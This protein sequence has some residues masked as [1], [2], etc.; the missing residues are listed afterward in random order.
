MKEA[1]Y[2]FFFFFLQYGFFFKDD[3][4]NMALDFS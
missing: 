2:L 3:L 4:Y 1:L